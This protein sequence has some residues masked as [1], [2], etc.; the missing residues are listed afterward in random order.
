[1]SPSAKL[2]VTMPRDGNVAAKSGDGSIRIE[3]VHGRLELRTG[4]GSIRGTDIAGQLTLSTGDGSVTLDGVGRRPRRRYRRRQRQRRG[5]ARRRASSTPATARS[6][7]APRPAQ[8]MKDDWS[9]TTGD[10]GVA[11][12]L[13][14]DFGAR[15]R[16]AHRR[17]HDPQRAAISNAGSDGQVSRRTVRGRARRRR[18]SPENPHGRRDIQPEGRADHVRLR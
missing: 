8:S 11:L 16:R 9:I 7:S 4:D 3:H 12:Y 15:A 2:I 6:R 1:M 18:Q 14:S 5:Q 10:G 17:R 13:P